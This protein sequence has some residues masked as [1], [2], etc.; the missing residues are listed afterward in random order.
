MENALVETVRL[1]RVD[2]VEIYPAAVG[3]IQEL[4]AHCHSRVFVR[5]FQSENIENFDFFHPA[6]LVQQLV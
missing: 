3:D 6:D 4:P 1:L 2:V 5:Y